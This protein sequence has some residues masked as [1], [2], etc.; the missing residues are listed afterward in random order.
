MNYVFEGIGIF[1]AFI[2]TIL[3]LLGTI[4]SFG[5]DAEIERL[6]EK[7]TKLEQKRKQR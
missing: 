6:K 1:S 7:V 5:N 4:I 3:V 2:I